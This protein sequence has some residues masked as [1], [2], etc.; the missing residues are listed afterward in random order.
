MPTSPWK[1][2]VSDNGKKYYYNAVTKQSLWE[3]PKEHQG[4][5]LSSAVS[6]VGSCRSILSS[7]LVSPIEYLDKMQSVALSFFL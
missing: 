5:L 2:H 1:E 6:P 7:V 3:M 4:M